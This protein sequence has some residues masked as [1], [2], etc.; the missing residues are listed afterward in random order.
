MQSF[1]WKKVLFSHVSPYLTGT[2]LRA[3]LHLIFCL[4]AT[5]I[6]GGV[7]SGI[8]ESL[9]A[10]VYIIKSGITPEP[11]REF[12]YVSNI[13]IASTFIHL[14]SDRDEMGAAT[15]PR[16]QDAKRLLS[17]SYALF[18]LSI[19]NS[20][21]NNK[22]DEAFANDGTAS[23]FPVCYETSIFLDLGSFLTSFSGWG[24]EFFS[25]VH[26]LHWSLYSLW[27][28]NSWNRLH[29]AISVIFRH[30][31]FIYTLLKCSDSI[32]CL[33]I[34]EEAFTILWFFHKRGILALNL[35]MRQLGLICSRSYSPPS[36]FN[37]ASNVSKNTTF[38]FAIMIQVAS[39]FW[40]GVCF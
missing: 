28:Q 11:S 1:Q 16:S 35:S 13:F 26:L 21:S 32:R 17:S 4:L 8:R 5:V 40:A 9:A 31:L 10:I 25:S 15:A 3:L 12:D 2:S 18:S 20:C 39:I 23:C 6:L 34:F 19:C 33:N 29:L 38:C 7:R 24:W 14:S 36:N 37:R 27:V 30:W 22:P